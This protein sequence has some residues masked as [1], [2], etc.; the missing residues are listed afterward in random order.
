MFLLVQ[1]LSCLIYFYFLFIF[2]TQPSSAERVTSSYAATHQ[3]AGASWSCV[4]MQ[5]VCYAVCSELR[6]EYLCIICSNEARVRSRVSPCQICGGRSGTVTGFSRSNTSV[7]F[8]I[9]IIPPVIFTHLHLNTRTALSEGQAGQVSSN[10][11]RL[12]LEH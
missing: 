8:P 9:V 4:H 6:I 10:S 7:F 1:I 12:Q 2:D 5:C 11:A 3:S